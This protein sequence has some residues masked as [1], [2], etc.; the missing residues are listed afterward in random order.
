MTQPRRVPN[1]ARVEFCIYISPEDGVSHELCDG[2][3]EL[4]DCIYE[5]ITRRRRAVERGQMRVQK[6]QLAVAHPEMNKKGTFCRRYRR[7]VQQ[8]LRFHECC[9][10]L[11]PWIAGGRDQITPVY[12]QDRLFARIGVDFLEKTHICLDV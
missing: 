7:S 11:S 6:M 5:E 12:L 4:L 3:G 8:N 1:P 10:L 2:R 9:E